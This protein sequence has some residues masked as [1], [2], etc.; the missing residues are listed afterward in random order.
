M[1]WLFSDNTNDLV[2]DLFFF[3]FK[4]EVDACD[5]VYSIKTTFS[6][7]SALGMCRFFQKHSF[8]FSD[9]S[10]VCIVATVATDKAL[11]AWG[12]FIT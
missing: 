5:Y 11:L 3:F 8:F 2:L 1:T 10:L 12:Q 7:N 4:T 6:L 9:K